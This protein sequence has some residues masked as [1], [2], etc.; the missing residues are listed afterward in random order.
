MRWVRIYDAEPKF[1]GDPF[2]D[3]IIAD[4]ESSM[5]GA[6]ID[7]APALIRLASEQHVGLFVRPILPRSR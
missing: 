2:T 3:Q 6:V 7:E 4:V 1:T 5:R